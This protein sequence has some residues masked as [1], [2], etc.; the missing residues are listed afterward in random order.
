[1]GP[2]PLAWGI[3]ADRAIE[4]RSLYVADRL[5]TAALVLV[6]TRDGI[7]HGVAAVANGVLA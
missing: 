2:G 7:E 5:I 4:V 1:M 3:A 6:H